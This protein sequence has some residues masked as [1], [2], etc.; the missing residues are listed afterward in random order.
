MFKVYHFDINGTILGTDSTDNASIEDMT[1]ESIARSINLVGEIV[2]GDQQTYYSFVKNNYKDYKR[3]VYNL[4][5]TFPQLADKHEKLLE[6]FKVG[7]FPSF[8]KLV[9]TEFKDNN[10]LLVLRTFGKDRGFVVT[11]LESKGLKFVSYE[12]DE[13]CPNIYNKCHEEGIHIMVTDDYKKWNNGGRSV[14]FGKEV[15]SYDGFEQYAFDDNLCMFCGDGVKF[16]HVNTLEAALDENY[17]I[18]LLRH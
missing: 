15:R 11:L 2:H 9:D 13:L 7:L 12:S 14:E 8:L 6:V 4:L 16:Y 18:N 5:D 3:Q 1:C 17:Y 10:S